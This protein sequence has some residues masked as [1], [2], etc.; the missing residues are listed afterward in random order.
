MHSFEDYK[1]VY[2]HGY[3]YRISIPKNMR[4]AL[5]IH[6]GD[7]LRIYVDGKRIVMEKAN[8]DF[9]ERKIT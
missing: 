4:E 1:K 9:T 7:Y 2:K 8:P 6:A 3:A 5:N